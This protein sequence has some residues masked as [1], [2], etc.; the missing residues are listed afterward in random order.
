MNPSL[1]NAGRWLLDRRSFLRWGGTGLGGMG[2][3]AL[4]Q[5][6][7]LLAA[8]SVA[9]PRVDPTNPYAP[10]LPHFTPKAK[11]V[12][13]IFCSGALS[14][15]DTFD[16]K[17]ELMKRDGKPLPGEDKLITLSGRER[18]SDSAAVGV[19]SRAGSAA[20]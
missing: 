3:A 19:S 10:R 7:R 2:L 12:V 15:L 4:L 1:S 17:P 18:Q 14:H 9:T 5:G 16:Y 6:D 13:M 20:R 11:R 8:E